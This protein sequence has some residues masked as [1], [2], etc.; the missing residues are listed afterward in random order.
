MQ[1]WLTT[2][3]PHATVGHP[4]HVYLKDKYRGSIATRIAVGDRVAFYEL[5]GKQGKG[6]EAVIALARV[7]G[8][9]TTNQ[10]RDG[11]P[12]IGDAVWDWQ[13][14]CDNHEFGGE[15]S[16]EVLYQI[17]E[18]SPRRQPLVPGGLVPLTDEQYQRIA[19]AF[20]TR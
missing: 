5:K 1:H 12:D 13:F 4:Y 7:A 2:H 6:R 9:L 19:Q 14:P 8:E 20:T 17:L 15:V 10:E 18:W 3:Y 11:G 16:K